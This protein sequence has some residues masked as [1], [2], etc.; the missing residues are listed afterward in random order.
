VLRTAKD[1]RDTKRVEWSLE[2]LIDSPK[3]ATLGI[4]GIVVSRIGLEG[5]RALESRES[6][7]YGFRIYRFTGSIENLDHALEAGSLEEIL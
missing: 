1:Y 6:R 7:E 4:H 3:L 5:F 2:N